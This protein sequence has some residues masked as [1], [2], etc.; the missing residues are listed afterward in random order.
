MKAADNP[1][2]PLPASV[3]SLENPPD[4]VL[5]P[6]IE[7]YLERCRILPGLPGVAGTDESREA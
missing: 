7:A 6:L 5:F 4:R 1:S 2:N 3:E